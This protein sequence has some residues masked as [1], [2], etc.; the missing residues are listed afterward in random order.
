MMG[1]KEV[2][3]PHVPQ[4]LGTTRDYERLQHPKD[5]GHFREPYEGRRL[6]LRPTDL[7]A[8]INADTFPNSEQPKYPATT[9]ASQLPQYYHST[10]SHLATQR[11]SD[12]S[13]SYAITSS[14]LQDQ[15]KPSSSG[16]PQIMKQNPIPSR[17]Q[18]TQF[19]V[20]VPSYANGSTQASNTLAAADHYFQACNLPRIASQ[21]ESSP[22]SSYHLFRQTQMSSTS[23]QCNQQQYPA[24]IP[25][26]PQGGLRNSLARLEDVRPHLIRN[27]PMLQTA[28]ESAQRWLGTIDIDMKSGSRRAAEKRRLKS[29]ASKMFR[30]RKKAKV[31]EMQETI[32][33]LT[34]ECDYLRRLCN[35]LGKSREAEINS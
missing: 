28:T 10:S 1:E 30:Q 22:R 18:P 8:I 23:T 31:E 35:R 11:R 5:L 14:R 15:G 13:P 32:E 27:P 21:H 17:E 6:P 34:K 16:S 7:R 4:L 20:P 3:Q 12:D 26:L 19:L 9:A 24:V 33:R 2:I 25:P 29:C